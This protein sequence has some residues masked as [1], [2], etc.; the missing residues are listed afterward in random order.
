LRDLIGTVSRHP[1]PHLGSGAVGPSGFEQQRAR[2]RVAS[3]CDGTGPDLATARALAGH[4]A[5][6]GHQ[7][8]RAG[9]AVEVPDLGD[10]RGR[11]HQ[12]NAPQSLQRLHERTKRPLG[13]DLG[14]L[15]LEIGFP[16][17]SL[18]QGVE[19]ALKGDLLGGMREAP[20]G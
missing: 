9:E 19:I 15:P 6:I 14:D 1:L 18:L 12:P 7:L 11:N 2:G 8:A 3:L 20:V 4:K 17:F 5:E 16:A 10:D 13:R